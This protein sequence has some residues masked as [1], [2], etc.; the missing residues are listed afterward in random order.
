M[1]FNLFTYY[2]GLEVIF[3]DTN[4]LKCK[5][6]QLTLNKKG[7]NLMTTNETNQIVS[8]ESKVDKVNKLIALSVNNNQKKE[9]TSAYLKALEIIK[10]ND[11]ELSQFK[12]NDHYTT[13]HKRYDDMIK[14]FKDGKN[15]LGHFHGKISGNI[16]YL[17]LTKKLTLKQL[18]SKTQ[19]S[20]SRIKDH[21][22]RD[23]KK[24]MRSKG[25]KKVKIHTETVNGKEL[26]YFTLTS[27]I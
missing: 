15:I 12:D 14:S 9:S 21:I 2:F 13:F 19:T 17:L 18:A 11:F 22:N 16:D 25:K 10:T 23:L 27:T 20:E 5:I 6:L 4:R 8:S 1:T 3:Y 26:Y 24:G 7:K